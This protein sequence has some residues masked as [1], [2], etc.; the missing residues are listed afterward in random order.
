MPVILSG[1]IDSPGRAKELL[2]YTGCNGIMIGR[3]AKGRLWIFSDLLLFFLGYCRGP[4]DAVFDPEISWK[5]EFSKLYLKFLIYFKGEGKAVR[6]FR[7]HLC[8]IFRGTR[9]IATARKKFF[10]IEKFEDAEKSIDSI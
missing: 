8:W 6:E 5:K 10:E 2:E 7:K 9:G 3:A 1:D 4:G